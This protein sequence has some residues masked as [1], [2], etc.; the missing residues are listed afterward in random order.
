MNRPGTSRALRSVRA[1]VFT[2]LII[3]FLDELVYGVHSTVLPL[4]QEDLGLSYEQLGYLI[5][6]P[7]LVANF[8]EPALGILGDVWR[9]RAIV[10]AGGVMYAFGLL[11][12]GVSQSFWP[13]LLAFTISS[14]ASG[15][16]VGL[17]QATLMD[18]DT[19]RHEH[20]MARWTFAGSVGVVAG[21]LTVGVAAALGVDWHTLFLM[22]AVVAAAVVGMA[23]RFPFPRGPHEEEEGHTSFKT[24]VVNALRAL[25]RGEV[26]RWLTL[27]EFSDLMLDIL[28]SFLA[29]YFVDVVHVEPP[30][31]ALA[32]TVWTAVGLVGDLLL[33]P[34]LERVRGLS[35][36]RVSVV[37]ELVLYP[38]FLL[39]P[40]VWAKIVLIGVLGLFNAGWYSILK[41]HLYSAMPGQSG[42]VMTLGSLF[43][44][45]SGLFPI[46]IGNLAGAYGLQ[47]A[48]WFMMLGPLALLVGLPR[49]LAA[50]APTE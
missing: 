19:A 7:T 35:Y 46:I 43:G 20:N 26:L 4:I 48:M 8:I 23:W 29:I 27:L 10:L 34:L 33:I 28:G 24:G 37:V 22:L 2:L 21:T 15:A 41:G 25:K 16:F 32:V 12:A 36:L 30:V 14:P 44:V 38:A 50:V 9:R 47:A 13:L 11:L 3:E 39:V 31:G 49:R 6:V 18:L 40:D 42:T 45:L 5:G 17:A 1:F